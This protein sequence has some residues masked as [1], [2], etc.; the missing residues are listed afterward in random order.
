[1]ASLIGKLVTKTKVKSSPNAIYDI[2]AH[3]PYELISV[4]PDVFQSLD[5]LDGL[6]GVFGCVFSL[7]YVDGGKIRTMNVKVAAI[8]DA[9]KTV[10]YMIIAGDLLSLYTTLSATVQVGTD[11]DGMM[12][13]VTWT[14]DYVKLLPT[15]PDPISLMNLAITGVEGIDAKLAN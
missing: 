15:S 1:M 6:W 9:N 11:P 7:T 4:A 13:F 5:L 12:N 10:T 2:Y 8:D 3:K 14:L